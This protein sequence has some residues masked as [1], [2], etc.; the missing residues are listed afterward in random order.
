M[1]L[2]EIRNGLEKAHLQITEFETS[3]KIADKQREVLRLTDVSMQ[4]D[5]WNDP[6]KAKKTLDEMNA[7]KKIVDQ[8]EDLKHSLE[9]LWETYELVKEE[10]DSDLK[11]LLDED[12][13]SFSQAYEAFEK[14]TLLAGSYDRLNA[15]LE[16][17]PGAG[18]TE[19][20]DWANMLF[21]MYTRYAEKKGYQVE[22]LDYLD[23]EEAGIKSVTIL[24]KGYNAYGHLKAERGVHR[25]VRI[26]PFD[27]NKRRHTSFASVD[28]M[29]EFNEDIDIEIRSEDLRIDTYR[30]SGA[31]GQHINKTD[32]AVRLTHLPTGIVVSCQSQ[33]SQIQ[34]REQAMIML[35]SKLYSEALR[36]QQEKLDE[37]RGEQKEI[38]WG[39]QIRSYVFHPYALVKDV[40]SGYETG[41]PQAVMDGDLDALIY[42]YL[43][44]TVN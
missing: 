36:Q 29:P 22:V 33:R 35:K 3:L 16:I 32:S 2:Y 15:I 18:G 23:G 11:E 39:S 44:S 4:E 14:E 25:L 13:L 31:G 10:D 43:K 40:R 28:V 42:A 21:R 26:S 37:I 12:Y 17:H 34:N 27:A 8:Y 41:N 24:V 5:F 19:S 9:N 30:A 1:E 6:Q 20:Q 7:M 38:A